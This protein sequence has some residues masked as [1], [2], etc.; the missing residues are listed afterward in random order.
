MISPLESGTPGRIRTYD[1]LLRRQ[2]LKACVSSKLL[3][4]LQRCVAE[5]LIKTARVA[6][7]PEDKADAI[8]AIV[9]ARRGKWRYRFMLLGKPHEGATGL[10][11]TKQ[12]LNAAK[13]IEAQARLEAS[14]PKKKLRKVK[15]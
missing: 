10:E 11:A 4:G 12:N 7:K 2:T 15:G 3:Q 5:L 14:L 13:A 8:S 1:L 9:S 6:V